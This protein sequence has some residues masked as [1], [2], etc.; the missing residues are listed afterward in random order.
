MKRSLSAKLLISFVTGFVALAT[1][2][3]MHR[4]QA[5]DTPKMP[6][7]G[8]LT[9]LS[10]H[11]MNGN[12]QTQA[13]WS[14]SKGIVIVFLGIECPISNGY[15]QELTRL[16]EYG[17]SRGVRF[18]GIHG[19]P[20]VSADQARKHA[21]DFGLKFPVLLDPQQSTARQVG[22]R[23]MPEAVVLRSSGEVIYRGR[24][25]DRYASIG[26]QRAA[27][28]RRDLQLAIDAVVANKLPEIAETKAIGCQLPRPSTKH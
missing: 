28:T 11:D 7:L 25:D 24:I 15:A 16:A 23:T 12:L 9:T 3:Q 20:D 17:E 21:R 18:L 5:D 13:D 27:P 19:D 4:A 22:A 8:K 6:T 14:A 2:L 1:M 26:R 10:L